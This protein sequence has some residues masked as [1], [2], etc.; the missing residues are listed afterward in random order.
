MLSSGFLFGGRARSAR[1]QWCGAGKRFQQV[2]DFSVARHVADDLSQFL[3]HER[4]RVL[5]D[6][7]K[8]IAVKL[9]V[10]LAAQE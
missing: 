3:G 1:R 6:Q 7:F 5:A 9:L 2:G 10:Q 4:L 8:E